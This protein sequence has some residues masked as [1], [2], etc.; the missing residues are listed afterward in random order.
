VPPSAH[1][2]IAWALRSLADRSHAPLAPDLI[3]LLHHP[4]IAPDAKWTIAET[5]GTF[6][7]KTMVPPLIQALSHPNVPP[8]VHYA[9]ARA[10]CPLADRSHAPALTELL[11]HPNI[12]SDAK[13]TIAEIISTFQEKTMVPPL[14]QPSPGHFLGRGV[15]RARRDRPQE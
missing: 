2:A 11:H 14:T 4:S 3:A 1:Y 12:S 7:E 10:F 9:I 15:K 5:I 6:Q 8:S 13:R